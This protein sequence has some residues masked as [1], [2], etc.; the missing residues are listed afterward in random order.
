MGRERVAMMALP[1]LSGWGQSCPE[2]RNMPK[3]GRLWKMMQS[4]DENQDRQC[5]M[6]SSR[7]FCADDGPHCSIRSTIEDVGTPTV[8]ESRGN[9]RDRVD[10]TRQSN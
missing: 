2:K 10:R 5:V 8:T 7:S 3:E 1:V 6:E 4:L 9:L